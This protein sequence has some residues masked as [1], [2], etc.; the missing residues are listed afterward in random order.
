MAKTIGLN[1]DVNSD[2]VGQATKKTE[3]IT[4]E[5][6]KLKR[7][8]ASGE[9][10]GD[11]FN[12]AAKRAAE[13]E[14]RVNKVR[15]AVKSLSDDNAKLTAFVDTAQG[16]AGG[17]AA[18]QGAAAL[19]GGENEELQKTFVKLQASMALLNGIQAFSNIL[20][21]ESALNTILLGR[22]NVTAT[23]S[24]NGLT[25]ATSKLNKALMVGAIGLAVAALAAIVVYAK[26]IAKWF[27]NIVKTNEE[28]IAGIEKTKTRIQANLDLID[29]QLQLMELQGESVVAIR[30]EKE[31]LLVLLLE[32]VKKQH[33]LQEI[34]VQQVREESKKVTFMD[35][36][37]AKFKGMITLG[38]EMAAI[39]EMHTKSV[40]KVNE[41]EEKLSEFKKE[42]LRIEILIA[43]LQKEKRDEAKSRA[44]KAS[45]EAEEAEKR[46][47]AAERVNRE[48]ALQLISDDNERE[49]ALLKLKHEREM[50]QAKINGEN[51]RLLE[52]L[53]FDEQLALQMKHDE[54]MQKHKDEIAAKE[55]ERRQKQEAAVKAQFDREVEMEQQRAESIVQFRESILN[56]T[57]SIFGSLSQLAKQNSAEQKALALAS[58]AA[59]TATALTGALSNSQSPTP[60]NIATGGLAGIAKYLTIG[61]TIL[62]AAARAKQVL[63]AG[64]GTMGS[65]PSVPTA[66]TTAPPAPDIGRGT[67]E[68]PE[69]R[70]YVL[71]DDI[72]RTQRRVANIREN[73]TI[74]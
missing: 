39:A 5:L 55:E 2:S 3:N 48:R 69:T 13:L 64:G 51:L 36:V 18:A 44:D 7:E 15:T 31:K 58:I 8:L 65:M 60:D 27:E 53:Q 61:A 63:G 72:S 37:I 28:L 46:R 67:T 38:G 25:V 70:V 66:N 23:A 6:R 49:L 52:Q 41:Q 24:T 29:L 45:K 62:S 20:R 4:T 50:E 11:A 17:F 73:A 21:K 42:Q 9:L 54:V 59:D 40:E 74:D 14:D 30:E 34:I 57:S 10:Q 56:S 32:E 26:D 71:E 1:I 68:I 47:L 19:F 16:I 35:G 43:G 33:E 12:Q 22:A